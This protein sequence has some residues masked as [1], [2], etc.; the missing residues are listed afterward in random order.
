MASVALVAEK[1]DHHP[2]WKNVYKT[3]DVELNT[4]DAGGVTEMDFKLARRMN[5][6]F[7]ASS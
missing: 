1:L 2:D 4:H 3:V 6:L 7:E 5:A